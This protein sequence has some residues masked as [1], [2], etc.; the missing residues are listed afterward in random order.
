MVEKPTLDVGKIVKSA[1]ISYDG[2]QFL[3]RIPREISRFFNLK[4]G[5]H[6]K[7]TVDVVAV[8][9]GKR[10]MLVEVE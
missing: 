7:L 1:S 4:K 5:G 2:K 10:M 8:I 3:I 6:M 9:K